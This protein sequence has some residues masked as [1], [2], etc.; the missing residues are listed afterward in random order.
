[1]GEISPLR[2]DQIMRIPSTDSVASLSLTS[3]VA[4]QVALPV[5][6]RVVAFSFS[7]DIWVSYGGSTVCAIVPSSNSSA[8]STQITEFNPTVRY[9][10]STFDSTGIN[11]YSDYTCKGSVSFYK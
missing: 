6:A 9:I 10:G 8:G 1:M 7:A 4:A 5:G 11:V 3:G 2:I